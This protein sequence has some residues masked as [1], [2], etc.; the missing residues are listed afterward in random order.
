[1]IGFILCEQY[2]TSLFLKKLSAINRLSEKL[3]DILPTLFYAD[4]VILRKWLFGESCIMG[5]CGV[6]RSEISTV[7]VPQMFPNRISDKNESRLVCLSC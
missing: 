1:M 4:E 2:R 6:V 7:V 5:N 3:M